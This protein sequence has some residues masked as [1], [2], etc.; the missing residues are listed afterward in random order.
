MKKILLISIFLFTALG[1]SLAI[2]PSLLLAEEVEQG[3]EQTP[4]QLKVLSESLSLTPQQI[5]EVEKI[6]AMVESQAQKDH[7]L[8]QGNVE[9][10]IAAAKRRLEMFDNAIQP[11]L[12]PD[13]VNLYSQQKR[14]RMREWEF[15]M[16]KEGLQLTPQ[17]CTT[18]KDL[19]DEYRTRRKQIMEKMMPEGF[20]ADEMGPG[21]EGGG[22][23]GG[24]D[25][26][27][28]GFRGGMGGGP[29][30]GPMRDEN[31]KLEKEKAAE[32]NLL[33][34]DTQKKMYKD[35]QKLIKKQRKELFK[36]MRPPRDHTRH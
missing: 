10:L 34:T 14:E 25:R 22:E 1:F 27:G 26:G 31:S 29:M 18:I 9:A 21:K 32:I 12:T 5:T 17:Q 23:R 4:N 19:L 24:E 35:L 6:I 3:A 28:H 2:T 33:L 11:L 30:A 20:D 8:Y 15:F 16:L 36:K 7:E 13:Q